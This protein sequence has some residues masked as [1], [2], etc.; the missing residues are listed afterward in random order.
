MVVAKKTILSEYATFKMVHQHYLEEADENF[1]NDM[2]TVNLEKKHL[3]IYFDV[4]GITVV[5]DTTP[6]K[7][8]TFT[9]D[10]HDAFDALIHS[11]VSIN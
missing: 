10:E 5:Y 9:Y 6:E 7:I 8:A 2:V 1:T 11:I 4:N 3:K